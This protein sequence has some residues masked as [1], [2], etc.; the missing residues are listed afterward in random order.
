VIFL[1][2]TKQEKQAK[3]RCREFIIKEK[4][5]AFLSESN[6]QCSHSQRAEIC[7]I[8]GSSL[9]KLLHCREMWSSEK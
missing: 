5:K 1:L 7:T 8:A 4:I 3:K 9:G 6:F 2:P